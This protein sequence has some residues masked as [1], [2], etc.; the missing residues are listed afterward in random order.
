VTVGAVAA[1]ALIGYALTRGPEPVRPF[2]TAEGSSAEAGSEGASAIGGGGEGGFGDG[3][4]AASRADGPPAVDLGGPGGSGDGDGRDGGEADPPT[5]GQGVEGDPGMATDLGIRIYISGCVGVPGIYEM[6]AG[7]SLHEAVEAAGGFTAEADRENV[8]LLFALDDGMWVRILPRVGAD[9][10]SEAGPELDASPGPG[11]GVGGPGDGSG[12]GV[13][14]GMG[15]A[16]PGA[17]VVPA[18]DGGG[19]PGSGGGADGAGGAAVAKDPTEARDGKVNVNTASAA[20]L[21][22]LP[23]IGPKTAEAIIA[24]REAFGPFARTNE[25]LNVKGIGAKKYEAIAGLITV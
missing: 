4:G 19:S 11:S 9:D 24:R 13:A 16:G 17:A 14:V 20:E 10:R 25:L 3:G 23:G 1:L 7:C 21:Q 6:R 22:T 12:G 18:A 2:G 15:G 8:N 5:A